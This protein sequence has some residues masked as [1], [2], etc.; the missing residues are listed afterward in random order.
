MKLKKILYPLILLLMAAGCKKEDAIVPDKIVPEYSLP[1]G[2]HPYDTQIVDFH[3]KYGCYILYKFTEKD[4]KWNITNNLLYTADQGDENYIAP[5]LDALEINICSNFI[6]RISLRKPCLIKS[7]F[8]PGSEKLLIIT[9][10]LLP[11]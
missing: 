1:Q 10:R 6:V 3:N 5:A 9:T 4:F 2:N 11:P 8:R 7:S